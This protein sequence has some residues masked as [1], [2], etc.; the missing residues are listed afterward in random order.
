MIAALAVFGGA[1]LMGASYL[2]FCEAFGPH[3]R[4]SWRYHQRHFDRAAWLAIASVLMV[5]AGL[6]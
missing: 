5:A 3:G 2:S 1:A 6:A 4:H